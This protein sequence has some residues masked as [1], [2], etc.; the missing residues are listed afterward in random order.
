[1]QK[2]QILFLSPA[3]SAGK[4]DSFSCS[5]FAR[6]LLLYPERACLL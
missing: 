3:F 2:Q 4:I 5:S 6:F 1:M